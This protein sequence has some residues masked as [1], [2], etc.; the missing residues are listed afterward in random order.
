MKMVVALVGLSVIVMIGLIFQAARQELS[1]RN[2]KSRMLENSAEVQNK[3]ETIDE[4]KANIQKL[5]TMLSPTNAKIDELNK[6]KE[7]M[8]QTVQNLD[9]NLQTC[10]K[11]KE[12]T[13]LKKAE[14][15]EDF[16]KIKAE[17]EVAKSKAQKDIQSLKQQVL[18][19]DRA[20]CT[21]ADTTKE[22]A[23][24]LCGINE[25]PQ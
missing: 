4:M 21:F 10:N 12:L 22:E 19:R 1:L 20:I 18:D 14:M 23:R 13:D 17:H 3:K 11:E 16:H 5:K 15:V 6:K 9:T 8:Q 2:L 7:G 25:A 24:K